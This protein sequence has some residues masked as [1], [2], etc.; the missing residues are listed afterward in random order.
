[1][2]YISD[3]ERDSAQQILTTYAN[4]IHTGDQLYIYVYSLVPVSAA[5]FNQETHTMTVEMSRLNTAGRSRN[6]IVNDTYRKASS[7]GVLGYPVDDKGYII[8]PV[9]GK[10]KVEGMTYDSLQTFIQNRLINEGYVLDP[11]VTVSP[12]NFRVSVVGEVR[13]PQELHISG[14]RLTI[15]EALAMCG[16]ITQYGLRDNVVVIREVKGEAIPIEID[17]TKKNMF[18]SEVYYLQQNDIV[19]VQP[20]IKRRRQ[21]DPRQTYKESIGPYASLG[22]SIAHVAWRIYRRYVIDKRGLF[23]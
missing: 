2:A 21:A 6:T 23:H 3:A 5:P 13:R 18:D 7:G 20:T 9:L 4:T 11:T 19:Y 15:F 14:E 8:F 16:D 22:V 10:M 12:L 17:L 1:M